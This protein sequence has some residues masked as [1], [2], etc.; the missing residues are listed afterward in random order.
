MRLFRYLRVP[1]RATAAVPR[2]LAA[3]RAKQATAL[4]T[5]HAVPNVESAQQR[6]ARVLFREG[7]R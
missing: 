6:A 1:P 7:D 2:I 5:V 3:M 4:V